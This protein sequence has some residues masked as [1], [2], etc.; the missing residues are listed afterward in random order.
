MP[1]LG[2]ATDM[3]KTS[4]AQKAAR[5]QFAKERELELQILCKRHP[6]FRVVR[7]VQLRNKISGTVHQIRA[8]CII[9]SED[10]G[11]II[12][13]ADNED[14]DPEVWNVSKR[15]TVLINRTKNMT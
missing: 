2:T 12:H 7:E 14:F 15:F 5:E 8:P 4:G 11:F 6:T 3:G 1:K 13:G 10:V 9:Q